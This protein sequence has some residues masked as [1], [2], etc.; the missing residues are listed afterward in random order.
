[1]ASPSETSPGE[2]TSQHHPEG[3]SGDGSWAGRARDRAS[4]FAQHASE[5]ATD[6]LEPAR[7]KVRD[8]AESQK[9]AGAERIDNMARAVHQAAD[10]IGAQ[11]PPQAAQYLHE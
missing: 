5:K 10:Q 1:M 4:D 3:H 2:P 8:V 9:A 7:R 6:V 11:L